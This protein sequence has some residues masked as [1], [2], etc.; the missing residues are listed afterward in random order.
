MF[1]G[2]F[3]TV[4][5][6]QNNIASGESASIGGGQ[7]NIA[8]VDLAAIGGGGYNQ[9]S[10]YA[11]IIAADVHGQR[12]YIQFMHGGV[13]GVAAKDGAFLWRYDEPANGQHGTD[14]GET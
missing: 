11:S 2:Q 1:L 10:G 6:G 9:A 13:V 4:A 8:S 5:G 12:Q 3:A 7:N 14:E